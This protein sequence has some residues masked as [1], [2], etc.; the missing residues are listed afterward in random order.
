MTAYEAASVLHGALR[1]VLEARQGVVPPVD[2]FRR[3]LVAEIG[4]MTFP[5]LEPWRSIEFIEGELREPH[6]TP[7]FNIA[8]GASRDDTD[9]S[10]PW[11][12]IRVAPRFSYM[13]GPIRVELTGYGVDSARVTLFRIDGNTVESIRTREVDFSANLA[14]QDFHV[15]RTGTFRISVEGN[16]GASASALTDL[17]LDWTYLI[18]VVTAALGALVGAIREGLTIR[19]TLGRI[20]LG[21]FAGFALTF[22]ALYGADV[23]GWFPFPSFGDEPYVNAV[24]TGLIGG[25]VGPYVLAE[26]FL[27]WALTLTWPAHRRGAGQDIPE[28][29]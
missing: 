21:T 6:T 22:S 4:R 29:L 24:V 17:W 1:S 9:V 15:F 27:S 12:E 13:E 5:S 8:R 19:V 14:S 23:A 7:I 16:G 3:E 10:R 25:L 11:V 26:A 2:V 18:S 20:L 28:G